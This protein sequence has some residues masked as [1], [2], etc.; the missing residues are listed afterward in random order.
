MKAAASVWDAYARAQKR[1]DRRQID[2][3]YWA[4]DQ[5]ADNLLDIIQAGVRPMSESALETMS[6]NWRRNLA[7]T[8]RRRAA[9]LEAHYKPHLVEAVQPPGE[10]ALDAARALERIRESTTSAE[11][12]LLERIGLGDTYAEAGDPMGLSEKAVERRVARLR[13]RL[14]L[15]A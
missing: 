8:A 3:Y 5:A 15:V 4:A 12:A 10:P 11:W 14:R 1:A 2:P 9:I 7:A 13:E 6:R